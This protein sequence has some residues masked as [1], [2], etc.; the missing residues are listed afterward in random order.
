MSEQRRHLRLPVESRTFIETVSPLVG[1]S[2]TGHLVTCKT[3][4]ISRGGLQVALT[5]E[6]TV[7][8]ILQIGVDLPDAQPLY[9]AGEVRWCMHNDQ[10][11]DYPWSAGFKLLNAYNS[12]IARWERLIKSMEDTP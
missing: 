8:A 3:M 5:E 10:D 2:G 7:G 9:L 11:K 4:N 6:V 12:D 1:K